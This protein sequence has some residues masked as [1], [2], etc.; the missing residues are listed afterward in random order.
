MGKD[1]DLE[2]S[3]IVKEAN[4][5]ETGDKIRCMEKEYSTIQAKKQPMTG[6]GK[7]IN[8]QG[9]EFFII[10]KWLLYELP[11]IIGIGLMSRNIG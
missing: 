8:S 11:L 5:W 1:M 2:H 3:S 9:T 10:K 7:M 6:S 4:T